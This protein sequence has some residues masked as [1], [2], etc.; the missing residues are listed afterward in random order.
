MY[1]KLLVEFFKG[2]RLEGTS[3]RPAPP[4]SPWWIV[5]RLLAPGAL[6][7]MNAEERAVVLI[8]INTG[9]RPSEIINLREARIV[10][11]SSIP[12]IQLRPD[13][14]VL[15]TEQSYRDIPL[16]GIAL[17]AMRQF[18]DGFPRYRDNGDNLSRAV[19]NYL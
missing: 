13:D 5:N 11:N 8:M 9:A 19:N 6:D 12:H 15:K 10:L 14:R 4:F 1:K 18:P 16:V 17:D 7:T 2:L 3:P